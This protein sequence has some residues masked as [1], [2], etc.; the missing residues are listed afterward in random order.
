MHLLRTIGWVLIFTLCVSPLTMAQTKP[1]QPDEVILIG[2][3]TRVMGIGGETTGWQLELK[4]DLTLA[5]QTFRVIEVSG[6]EKKLARLANQE[7]KARGFIKH[8]KGV[9]RKDWLVLEITSIKIQ[10]PT[11]TA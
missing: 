9:E 10:S 8:R 1:L 6:P 2:K 5:G 7:V 11:G 3:L 4:S